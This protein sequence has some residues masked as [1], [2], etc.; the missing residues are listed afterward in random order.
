M[1]SAYEPRVRLVVLVGPSQDSPAQN[2]RSNS[3]ITSRTG[4]RIPFDS[5]I[6]GGNVRASAVVKVSLVASSRAI[7]FGS[8]ASD[9]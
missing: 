7:T 2:Q 8:A 3:P 6:T 9:R 1:P 5:R 4:A